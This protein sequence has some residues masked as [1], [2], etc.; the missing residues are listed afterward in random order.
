[1][2]NFFSPLHGGGSIEAAYQLSRALVR[3]GQEVMIYTSDFELDQEYINYLSE[4]KVYPFHNWLKLAELC[5][6]P[7]IFRKAK[8]EVSSFDIIHLH[9]YRTFQNIVAHHYA[10]KY[11]IPYILQAHG[12]LPKIMAKQRLKQ[13]YDNIWGYRLLKDASKVIALTEMEAEQYKSMG[14]AEDKIEI[15]PNGIDLS[16]FENLPPRGEFRK[17]WNIDD[18]QRIVLYLGR[19]HKIKGLD[20]LVKAFADLTK[21]LSAIRLVIAGSDDGYL[22]ELQKLIRELKI[23]E[24]VLSTG[25]LYGRDK[26]EAYV[27]ADVYVLPSIYEIFGITVLEALACGTPVIL[28]DR[29]GIADVINSQAGLVVPYDKD[30]LSNAIGYMLN[31][32]KRRQDLSKKDKLLVHEQFDW[33]KIAGLVENV[34]LKAVYHQEVES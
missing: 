32:D 22:P 17:K 14:V 27:D 25:L 20:L 9:N 16:E 5:L 33:A 11:D 15:V 28:T 19:I 13:V 10:M 26:L 12:S 18:S 30:Q 4:V 2:V 21:R 8:R 7:A 1:M 34:Y 23:G 31:D 29:C 6:T 24:K 3:R